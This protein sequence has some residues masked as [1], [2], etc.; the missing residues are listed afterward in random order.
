M[1]SINLALSGVSGSPKITVGALESQGYRARRYKAKTFSLPVMSARFFP[2]LFALSLTA[3]L[4]AAE[5]PNVLILLADDLGYADLHCYG[6]VIDTPNLDRLAAN[7][8]RFTD[9]HNTARC[10]PTR[11]ALM[12]GFYPQQVRMDPPP[13]RKGKGTSPGFPSWARTLPQMLKP[14]GYRSYHSGKWHVACAPRIVADAGFDRSYHVEDQDRHFSPRRHELDDKPLPPVERSAGYYGPVAIADHA[15][16]FLK[17]HAAQHAQEPFFAYVAMTVP[18]FPVMAPPEDIAKYKDKFARGWD[19]MREEQFQRVKQLGLVNCEL[20]APEGQIRAPSGNDKTPEQ[21]GPNEVFT[22]Q[23]WA[24]LTPEQQAYQATKM[25]VHAAMI[26]R[27]DRELGRVIDQVKA[28]GQLDNTLIMFLSDNGASAEIMVRG[29]GNDLTAPMGSAASYLCL[30]PGWASVSNVP[31]RRFKI[32]THEGGTSTPLIVHWPKG[33]AAKGELRHDPGHVVDLMPTILDAAGAP[34]AKVS[35]TAP[36][37]PGKSLL[38]AFAKDNSVTHDWLFFHHEGNRGLRVGSLKLVSSK[39]DS[40]TW[41]LYDF[42]TD[43]SEQHNLAPKMP[44]K[45]AELQAQWESI[46]A[47]FLKDAQ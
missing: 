37:F 5:R 7:G 25:A 36:A 41:E 35:D 18:H 15:V 23:K 43:R 45:A 39:N 4:T 1:A 9:F 28:M 17:D 19:V 47:Q 8:L 46:Q 11:G 31:F 34:Q 24:E 16:E 10:W 30:G 29:D 20:S 38:P 26:D 12:T 14:L 21:T 2:L 44:A 13:G 3:S 22:Y 40:D 42:T 33:I 6:S 32:W 27:M